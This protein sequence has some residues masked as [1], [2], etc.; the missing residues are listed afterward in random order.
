MSS[1]LILSSYD[2]SNLSA[3]VNDLSSATNNTGVKLIY[4]ITAEVDGNTISLKWNE[5]MEQ[6]VVDDRIGSG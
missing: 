4:D 5:G 1:P 6:Y 3:F 2:L